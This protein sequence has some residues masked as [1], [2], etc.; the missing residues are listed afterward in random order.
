[1]MRYLWTQL[2]LNLNINYLVAFDNYREGDG[3]RPVRVADP[4]PSAHMERTYETTQTF[5]D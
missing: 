2:K 3:R 5:Q 4:C 1:M